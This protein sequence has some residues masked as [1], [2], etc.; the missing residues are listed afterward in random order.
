MIRRDGADGSRA[1]TAPRHEGADTEAVVRAP[2]TA[3]REAGITIMDQDR[4][5][6]DEAKQ[7][8]VKASGGGTRIGVTVRQAGDPSMGPWKRAMGVAPGVQWRPPYPQPGRPWAKL[9][10][11]LALFDVDQ[12]AP[13]I[14]PK[15]P[16]LPL[17]TPEALHGGTPTA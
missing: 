15:R 7:Q 9:A 14:A 2:S 1:L 6:D 8:R 12:G 5:T 11:D 10:A 16:L 17:Q 3:P 13:P 4:M